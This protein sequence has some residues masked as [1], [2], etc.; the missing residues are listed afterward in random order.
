VII[1]S[2]IS[3]WIFL[4]LWEPDRLIFTRFCIRL[5]LTHCLSSEPLPLPPDSHIEP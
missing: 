2:P 5:I 1:F 4:L 3:S